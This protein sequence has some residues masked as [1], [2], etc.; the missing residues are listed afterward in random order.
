MSSELATVETQ[1]EIAIASGKLK[2]LAARANEAHGRVDRAVRQS[3]LDALEAGEA[4]L[5]AQRYCLGRRRDWL[6]SNFNGSV[7]TGQRYVQFARECRQI[8]GFDASRATLLSPRQLGEI[9]TRLLRQRDTRKKP[10]PHP[11]LSSKPASAPRSTAG[12]PAVA[13][14]IDPLPPL[15]EL[16]WQLLEGLRAIALS[17]E[18]DDGSYCESLLSDLQ[19]HYDDMLEYLDFRQ[20]RRASPAQR[21]S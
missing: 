15:A 6:L 21:N 7:R 20:E 9:W 5:Q 3:L 18:P 1:S 10:T 19:P 14:P 12:P 13:P 4:L 2:E 11:A 8:G 17:D 16:F